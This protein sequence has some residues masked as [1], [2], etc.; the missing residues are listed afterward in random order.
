MTT[1]SCFIHW[2]FWLKY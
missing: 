2:K 1:V